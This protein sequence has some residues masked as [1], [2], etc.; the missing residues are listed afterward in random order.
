MLK[1]SSQVELAV[2]EEV[3]AEVAVVEEV[4]DQSDK[5]S[6][7]EVGGSNLKSRG[8]RHGGNGRRLGRRRGGQRVWAGQA[9]ALN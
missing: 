2:G 6:K 3:A 8:G 7:E 4:V 1:L 5:R 9:L